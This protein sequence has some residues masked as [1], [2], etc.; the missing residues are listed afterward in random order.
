MSELMN[1]RGLMKTAGAAAALLTAGPFAGT[2]VQ[3][4]PKKGGHFR[5]AI[6]GG[7]TGDSFDPITF[8]DLFMAVLGAGA[9]YSRLTEVDADG[10]V[11]PRA[12]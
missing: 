9:V 6:P 11:T 3:A 7:Q 1:R 5:A 8:S 10:K 4:A 12:S 2:L